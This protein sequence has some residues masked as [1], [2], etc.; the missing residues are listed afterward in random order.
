MLEDTVNGATNGTTATTGHE[1]TRD[2]PAPDA[3]TP[4]APTLRGAAPTIRL[5]TSADEMGAVSRVLQQVWG[6]VAPIVTTE[7]LMAISHSG[8]YVAAAIDD[9]GHALGASV[10]LLARHHGDDALHSHITGVLPGV[11]GT[12]AGRL[13]KLHQRAWA[14]ERNIDWI[15]W[16]FDPLVRRNAWFN[17]AVLG[18]EIDAYLPSFYGTM[19]DAINAGDESDRLLVAWHTPTGAPTTVRDASDHRTAAQTT[20]RVATPD[21]IVAL[22][23]TDPAAARSWRHRVRDEL[24]AALGRGDRVIGFSRSGDYVFGSGE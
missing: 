9:E 16:T 19:T 6:T 22:R 11:R 5:L 12:G 10:A 14:R 4:D 20:A 7:M 24:I 23:R 8:G 3:P 21:D 15:V 13:L 2:A 18:A 17:L 1:P